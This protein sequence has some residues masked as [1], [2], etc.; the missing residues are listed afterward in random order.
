LDYFLLALVIIIVLYFLGS[1]VT[2]VWRKG[3]K[4]IG[5]QGEAAVAR[6]LDKLSD[7]YTVINDLLLVS[8]SNSTQIDH[9]V[10]SYYGI[11]VIETKNIH[12]KV[13]GSGGAEFWTQY[14]PQEEHKFRNPI[15]QNNGHVRAI[16]RLLSNR[17]VPIYGVV[18]FPNETELHVSCEYP[19]LPW[20]DVV[21]YIESQKTACLGPEE[22]EEIA[23]FIKS[24]NHVGEEAKNAHIVNVHNNMGRRNEMVSSGR[25][26]LCGGQLVLRNG[27]Y[28]KFWGCSN[29]PK[30]KYILRDF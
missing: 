6:R 5:D 7:K 1:K 26:P 12:G 15:W 17:K 9:I 21:S 8:D 3:A 13:Y 20:R 14:L 25:C 4:Q 27:K 19:V 18:A 2:S 29:Y 23:S 10:V 22:V 11:F 30:C 24:Y 28:G 16:K